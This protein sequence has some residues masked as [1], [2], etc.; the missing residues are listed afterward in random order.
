MS[1]HMSYHS[2][3]THIHTHTAGESTTPCAAG[4]RS[5]TKCSAS[6]SGRILPAS[7][8]LSHCVWPAIHGIH[9]VFVSHSPSRW[10]WW[11][12]SEVILS[13]SPSPLIILLLTNL[14]HHTF[15][16]HKITILRHHTYSH[17]THTKQAARVFC[18]RHGSVFPGLENLWGLTEKQ[19][20]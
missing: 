7:R 18:R 10:W 6:D 2:L 13:L 16:Q 15:S 17:K 1:Y 19:P 20:K 12:F 8:S 14:S 11:W 4:N 5:F 9:G 3:H